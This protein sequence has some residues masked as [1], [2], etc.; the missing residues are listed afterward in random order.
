[1]D[2]ALRT[3]DPRIHALGECAEH[4]GRTYGLVA[5][6]YEQAAV[7]AHVLAG[8]ADAAYPGSLEATSLK[9]S[10]VRIY[11]A[12]APQLPSG[13]QSLVYR[14]PGAG[15]YKRLAVRDGKLIGAV[16]C[17]DTGDGPWYAELIRGG[18]AVAPM[19][20]ALMFGQAQVRAQGTLQGYEAAG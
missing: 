12:G 13:S 18:Q 1:V 19:R 15:I 14:D 8:R 7:C 2:D 11:A 5:P 17:G 4:R 9:V 10:G 20:E 16:L 6:L 3:S